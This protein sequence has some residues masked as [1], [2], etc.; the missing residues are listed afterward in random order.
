MLSPALQNR[1]QTRRKNAAFQKVFLQENVTISC[2]SA[3]FNTEKSRNENVLMKNRI[4]VQ[5]KV[6]SVAAGGKW[7]TNPS[8]QEKPLFT[9]QTW[10]P[11]VF[12]S[13][14][15]LGIQFSSPGKELCSIFPF[16]GTSQPS[17]APKGSL[18]C[19]LL[20][21][22]LLC[23]DVRVNNNRQDMGFYQRNWF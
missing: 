8:T 3:R 15:F 2:L 14:R 11:A 4:Q 9:S 19:A 13:L 23:Y 21:W 22:V 10:S 16:A 12:L 5:R 7:R 18:N 6:R 17:N 1:L 20:Q